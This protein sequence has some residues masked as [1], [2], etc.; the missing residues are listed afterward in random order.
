MQLEKIEIRGFKSFADATEVHF[1]QSVTGV[2]GPNGSGKSNIVDAFRW[3]LGEQKSNELRLEKMIDVLFNGSEKRKRANKARVAI[4]FS[5]TK[6]IL[7]LEYQTVTIA[8]ELHRSGESNYF[9]NNVS[10]RLKDIRNLF[11]D[12]GIGPNSYAIIALQMVEGILADTNNERR[13]MFEQAAGVSKYKTRKKET[14]NKLKLTEGDLDRVEDL[15]F[16]IDG[17]LKSLEK[18]AKRAKKFKEIKEQYAE[19]SLVIARREWEG[20]TRSIAELKGKID[21]AIVDHKSSEAKR[22]QKEAEIAERKS[23]ILSEESQLSEKQK[24][25]NSFLDAL[26]RKENERNEKRNQLNYLKE[27][28]TTNAF[29][30]K[31]NWEEIDKYDEELVDLSEDLT[32]NAATLV[33]IVEEH[34]KN[35]EQLKSIEEE[36]STQRGQRSEIVPALREAEQNRYSTEKRLAILENQL[37][38]FGE[39]QKRKESERSEIDSNLQNLEVDRNKWKQ[40]EN[41]LEDLMLQVNLRI[42]SKRKEKEEQST[43]LD[44]K[45]DDVSKTSRALDARSNEYE[46]LQS[47]VDNLEGFPESIKFLKKD[48]SWNVDAPLF[49]D[50]ITCEEKYRAVIESYLEPYLNHFIVSDDNEA[51]RAIRLLSEGQ[52]GRAQ[53]FVLNRLPSSQNTVSLPSAQRAVDLIDVEP[54]FQ[55]L[56]AAILHQVYVF[57]DLPFNELKPAAGETYLSMKG[58]IVY[59]DFDL[60][61]GSIGLFSGKKIGRKKNLQKLLKEIDGLK[62]RKDKFNSEI[63][64]AR[65]ALDAINLESEEKD[66]R[67]LQNELTEVQRFLAK[68]EAQMTAVLSRKENISKEETTAELLWKQQSDESEELKLSLID[69]SDK[70]DKLRSTLESADSGLSR[71]E[72]ILQESRAKYNQSEIDRIKAQNAVQSLEKDCGFRKNRISQLTDSSQKIEDELHN[73]SEQSNTLQAENAGIET[74][75]QE[76][77]KLKEERS[78]E[79]GKN[80]E[81]YYKRRGEINDIEES[82]RKIQQNYLNQQSLINQMKDKSG[83]IS[84]SRRAITDRVQIEFQKQLDEVEL[85]EMTDEELAEKV[86]KLDRLQNRIGNYGEINPLAVEAYDEMNER[87][88][89]IETERK[90]ILDAKE[91]LLLTIKEIDNTATTKYLEAF[92]QINIYFKEVFRSLFSENDD[93]ELIL[94]NPETPLESNIE[95]IAKPK[96]KRPRTLSQLSGG[97]KTL[98][99]TALLFSLYL[100]KPAPFCIFDEVDAPLDDANIKKFNN[101]VKD[102]ADRSQFVIITH[103]KETMTAMDVIYG[104][105]MDQPGV[106]RVGAVDFSQVDYAQTA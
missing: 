50:I 45:K 106:S 102:F 18:Q 30:L 89:K 42:E 61:G 77:Y 38:Q 21:D 81:E 40:E 70:L 17:N 44:Q 28:Q 46:L 97:E 63:Q 83:Q 68:A 80:E 43:L 33:R 7:P 94:L 87:K 19:S 47:M 23:S 62:L 91:S 79:I 4:T 1:G 5:N 51:F 58:Q 105:F 98:T 99:A 13:R 60:S 65:L 104:V 101:I 103:N 72:K 54:R 22:A 2:V 24:E 74:Y 71:K 12:T 39:Q 29:Q 93:C 26:R 73:I 8:R 64:Q 32:D 20:Y 76:S 59:S 6:N 55:E 56:L 92:D 52:K 75:L 100:L 69:L 34:D 27:K 88:T 57:E 3:V 36:Y 48:S 84:F 82:L 31:K 35:A 90:D 86:I 95:I 85:I 67:G 49:S 53:F 16:E 41:R 37:S 66:L 15:L 9:I 14:L 78:K 96:G 11:S 25:L 10:C